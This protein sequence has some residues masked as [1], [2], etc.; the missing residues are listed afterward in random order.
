MEAAR[1]LDVIR[2]YVEDATVPGAVVGVLDAGVPS[3]AAAGMT[4]PDG[5][6]P[7]TPEAVLRISSNTKPI[8]AALALMLI[9]E[10]TLALT[11]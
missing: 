11:G 5:S 3:V 9:E 2:P 1:F 6:T 8:V 10:G 7:L 4:E